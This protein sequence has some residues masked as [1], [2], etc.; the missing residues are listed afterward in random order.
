MLDN[1]NLDSFTR[2]IGNQEYIIENG[3]IT[4]KKIERKRPFLSKINQSI[5][6]STK[7]VTMD[8]ETRTI[9]GIMIPYCVSIFDGSSPISFYLSE[10]D[11][12]EEMLKTSILYLKKRKFHQY[13]V[14]LHNFSHF[15]GI[16]LL[17]VLSSLTKE[18]RPIIRDGRIIDLKFTFYSNKTKYLLYFR[19][20]YLLLPSS[21]K[22]LAKNF[23]VENKGIFPY[24]FINLNTTNLDYV[25]KISDFYNFYNI[26]IEQY[27][28]Y[29][30]FFCF[31]H[32]KIKIGILKKS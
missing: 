29:L 15:D 27:K 26:S 2:Q 28:L 19:Y 13:K 12:A 5:F 7:I 8:L 16:F 31:F 32:L 22:K 30:F 6:R 20:Y 24:S 11:S 1:Y 10:Y 3:K 17:R 23:K 25:G 4:L 18:I 9:D 14:Y 21:L